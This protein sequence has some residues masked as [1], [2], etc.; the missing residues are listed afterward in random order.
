MGSRP[1]KGQE[2]ILIG[3]P[4]DPGYLATRVVLVFPHFR[5][6]DD[7]DLI[8]RSKCGET[9]G[10]GV[11]ETE[12]QAVVADFLNDAQVG[13]V[14]VD[15]II[16]HAGEAA[17]VHEDL[18]LAVGKLEDVGPSRAGADRVAGRRDIHPLKGD[19]LGELAHET[20]PG[21]G[22]KITIP[23]HDVFAACGVDADGIA[24]DVAEMI[25][26]IRFEPALSVRIVQADLALAEIPRDCVQLPMRIPTPRSAGT[27]AAALLQIERL[28]ERAWPPIA[29]PAELPVLNRIVG[30][31]GYLYDSMRG[32]GF[33]HPQFGNGG[34]LEIEHQSGERDVPRVAIENFHHFAVVENCGFAGT[35]HAAALETEMLAPVN[36]DADRLWLVGVHRVRHEHGNACDIPDADGVDAW[37][38]LEYHRFLRRSPAHWLEGFLLLARRDDRLVPGS[39][40]D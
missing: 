1:V 9:I 16:L 17:G 21:E 33:K 35:V 6:A 5:V 23:E 11:H 8:A 27:M 7:G 32:S 38:K 31:L 24:F 4:F 15:G 10:L 3:F 26:V 29:P 18:A 39:Q 25:L 20:H 30:A 13:A 34:A 28:A 2:P 36:Q 12:Q 19:V 40:L 37:Q 14:A 22:I